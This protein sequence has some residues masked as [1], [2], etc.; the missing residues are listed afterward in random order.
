MPTIP[1]RPTLAAGLAAAL[2]AALLG[3]VLLAGP[4]LAHVELDPARAAAG[5]SDVLL[6]FSAEAESPSAGVRMVR[7]VLPAG[8]APG[9]V[10]LQR[11]PGGWRLTPAADGYTLAGPALPVGRQVTWA[12]TVRR[13][14]DAPAAV[15]KTLVT[16]SD[17]RVDRW[18]QVP[19]AGAPEPDNPAPVL[20]LTGA[21]AAAPPARPAPPVATQAPSAAPAAAREGGSAGWG[22]VVAV[23][24]VAAVVAGLAV[25]RRRARR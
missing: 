10:R 20:V 23:V 19:Q 7:M 6:T 15:F 3:P 5:A 1:C 11:G 18:V 4:A 8:V 13:L 22:L 2:A 25:G 17:G 24:A 21:R 16:Y 14:P 9:D 12:V